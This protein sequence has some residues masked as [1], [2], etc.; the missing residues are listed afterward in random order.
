VTK[1]CI[2]TKLGTCSRDLCI[3]FPSETACVI[4]VHFTASSPPFTP[5]IT[6]SVYLPSTILL[7]TT[8]LAPFHWPLQKSLHFPF[9]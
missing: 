5:Q 1:L 8:F 2:E 7:Y 4:F 9:S 6:C 3:S